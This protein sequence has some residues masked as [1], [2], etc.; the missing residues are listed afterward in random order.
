[1]RATMNALT[2]SWLSLLACLAI[3][4]AAVP[5]LGLLGVA[6]YTLVSPVLRLG[7]PPLRQMD[8][9]V[10]W[11][12]AILTP[13]VWAPSFLL[14]GLVNRALRRRGWRRG[15]RAGAYLAILWLAGVA[16]WWGMLR[17]YGE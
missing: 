12:L 17:L 14:A 9:A 13:I 16:A 5:S 6:H 11:P 4:M 10:S 3:M 1:M 7:F 8:E 15:W 2:E